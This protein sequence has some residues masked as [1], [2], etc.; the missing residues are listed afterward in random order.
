ML[1]GIDHVLLAL[2]SRQFSTNE[3]TANGKQKYGQK[4]ALHRLILGK[5]SRGPMGRLMQWN[6]RESLARRKRPRKRE[7]GSSTEKLATCGQPDARPCHGRRD[8]PGRNVSAASFAGCAIR[9]STGVVARP[10]LFLLDGIDGQD[11]FQQCAQVG[12]GGNL[13]GR[14]AFAGHVEQ[15]GPAF[16]VAE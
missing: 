14:A 1:A 13:E 11:Q 6:V 12:R 5:R 2:V 9:C 4:T 10:R 3:R 15:S 7:S 16:F 8:A